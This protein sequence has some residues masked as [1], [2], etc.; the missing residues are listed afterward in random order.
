MRNYAISLVLL[1]LMVALIVIW[2]SRSPQMRPLGQRL[3][4]FDWESLSYG[5]KVQFT[6]GYALGMRRGQ[7]WGC[8]MGAHLFGPPR[9]PYNVEFPTQAAFRCPEELPA[10]HITPDYHAERVTKYYRKYPED[11]ERALEEVFDEVR[12]GDALTL[13][14]IHAVIHGEKLN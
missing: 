3:D 13:E 14:E 7:D 8:G 10:F 5:E 2:S 12:Y 1:S 9:D 4:G 11:G 6:Y